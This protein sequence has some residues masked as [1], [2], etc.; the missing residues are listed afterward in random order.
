LNKNVE[1]VEEVEKVE[2]AWFCKELDQRQSAR[3]ADKSFFS[4]V[5]SNLWI[6]SSFNFFC[7]HLSGEE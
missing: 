7:L 1:K 5:D 4:S 6:I 2:N 3:S